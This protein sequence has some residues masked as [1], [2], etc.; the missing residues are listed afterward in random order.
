VPAGT[1]TV[2][3]TR[4]GFAGVTATTI[5]AESGIVTGRRPPNPAPGETSRRSFT[6]AP[7]ADV[8]PSAAA[9]SRL[10][11]PQRRRL[12]PAC[13]AAVRD[14]SRAVPVILR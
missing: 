13:T 11:E 2:M 5:V 4:A 6:P 7:D 3:L 14:R 12:W 9:R 10:T 8:H 1:W